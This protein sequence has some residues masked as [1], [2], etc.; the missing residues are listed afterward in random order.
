MFITCRDFGVIFYFDALCRSE[1]A[2]LQMY[3]KRGNAAGHEVQLRLLMCNTNS[4]FS[5]Q[6]LSG[7]QSRAL[8]MLIIETNVRWASDTCILDPLKLG[9][10]S[11]S[12]T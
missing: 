3:V 6:V 8:H 11:F 1:A 12:S 5:R 2:I 10:S 7:K 4:G 9:F